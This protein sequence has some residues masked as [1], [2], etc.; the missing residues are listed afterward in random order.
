MELRYV[1]YVV[2]VVLAL[3]PIAN[4]FSTAPS[5]IALSKNSSASEKVRL[6][7][8]A[9]IYMAMILIVF[10]IAGS[11]LMSFFGITVNS[12]RIAGGLI[13]LI[14][15]SRMLFPGPAEL[16][17][18]DVVSGSGEL[19]N[20][21]FVPLALPMLSGPGAISIVIGMSAEVAAREA[22]F[23]RIM[24][25]ITVGIGILLTALIC[26]LILRVA[27]KVV[28][29]FGENGISAFTRIMG[30][31]LICIGVEFIAGG[32][33]GMILRFITLLNEPA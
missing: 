26:F 3:L 24:A 25:Y 22:G 29:Y 23:Q 11:L 31:F 10:L 6:A 5:F 16:N 32:M 7:K 9:C 18:G 15:G 19:S 13:I 4:P 17:N 20:F 27:G 28:D 14:I 30:F 8:S 21:A 12:L 33:E 2:L 1:E